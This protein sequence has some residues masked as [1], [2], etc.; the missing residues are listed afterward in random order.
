MEANYSKDIDPLHL[1]AVRVR[2]Q[3]VKGDE[4]CVMSR[5]YA[6]LVLMLGHRQA[7]AL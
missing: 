7:I 1:R 2:I 6:I 5:V 4:I 3:S